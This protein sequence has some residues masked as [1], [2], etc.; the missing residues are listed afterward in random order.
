LNG[1]IGIMSAKFTKFILPNG[2]SFSG[3]R[4]TNAANF[5]AS[6]DATQRIDLANGG[7]VTANVHNYFNSGYFGQYDNTPEVHQKSFNK[8][9]ISLTYNA[10]DKRWF[11]RAWVLNVANTAVRGG[12]ASLFPGLA[13]RFIDPPRTYGI[14]IGTKW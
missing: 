13:A 7:D 9:D 14:S 12:D 5:T 1:G 11:A 3:N 4:L 10:R 8:T 2:Q 6:V